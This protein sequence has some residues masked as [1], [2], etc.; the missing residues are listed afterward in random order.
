MYI[1]MNI[2]MYYQQPLKLP[3][4]QR[5]RELGGHLWHFHLYTHVNMYI[6]IYVYIY[7]SN[8]LLNC[9]TA[10]RARELG[11]TFGILVDEHGFIAEVAQHTATYR[12]ALQHTATHC[13]TLQHT[14]THCNTL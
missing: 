10:M 5:A 7:T 3:R 11:G 13:N 6:Y 12:N 4:S 1:Y 8:Y 2:F 14:A 9:L